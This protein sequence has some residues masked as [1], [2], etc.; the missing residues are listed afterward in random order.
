MVAGGS[1]IAAEKATQTKK[2]KEQKVKKTKIA[3]I[4]TLCLLLGTVAA[5]AESIKQARPE[6]TQPKAVSSVKTASSNRVQTP[7]YTDSKQGYRLVTDVLDCLA[8]RL[9]SANYRIPV[10]SG[11][12]PS[13][14]GLS[15]STNWGVKAG[16]VYASKVAHGD[17]NADGVVNVGDAIYT[18]NY[19]F[20]NGPVPCPMEAGDA[21][22]TGAV[23][24]GDA[25][26]VLNYLFKGGPAPAC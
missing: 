20:K 10:N 14:V 15:Q 17:P 6:K 3:I 19:L 1:L 13:A 7:I 18:L 23:D 24:L 4:L 25:I 12:Q 22:C 16:F 9:E 2:A 8:G 26:Y 5:F 11:G 21:N